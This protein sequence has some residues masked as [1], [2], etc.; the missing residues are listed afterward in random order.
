MDAGNFNHSVLFDTRLGFGGNGSSSDSCIK[1]GPF[2][3]YVNH[4]GPFYSN[5]DH[6]INRNVNETASSLSAQ[7]YV[8]PCMA[9]P[10][11]AC[12]WR[13]IE[14]NPHLGGHGGV[15]LLVRS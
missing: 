3:D 10:D 4:I 7:N 2:K 11:Y 5:T 14:I 1:D 13:C 8:D 12:A 9:C 6:C 15:G